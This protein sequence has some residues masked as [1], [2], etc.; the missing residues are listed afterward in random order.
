MHKLHLPV[1]GKYGCAFPRIFHVPM[2]S[3][4]LSF[5]F[6]MCSLSDVADDLC[7]SLKLDVC[8]LYRVKNSFFVIS[9]YIYM[10]IYIYIYIYIYVYIFFPSIW[11]ITLSWYGGLRAPMILRA[12]P[13][14]AL[15]PWGHPCWTG[16]KFRSQTN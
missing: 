7:L 8:W 1:V 15:A 13:A 10:H 5:S 6:Q 2:W 3:A 16:Q 12:M 11:S 14:G 4:L 9:M